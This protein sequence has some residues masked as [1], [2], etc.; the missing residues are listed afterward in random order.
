VSIKRSVLNY[1]IS[2]VFCNLTIT[3]VIVIV[4]I[5]ITCVDKNR[6]N[7]IKEKKDNLIYI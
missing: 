4:I 2:R 1:Y 3:I 5:I 6:D 7:R